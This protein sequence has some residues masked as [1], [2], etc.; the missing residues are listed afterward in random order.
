DNSAAI[1]HKW[2]VTS[3][4]GEA[5]RYVGQPADYFDFGNTDT[6]IE[7]VGGRYDTLYY[8]LHSDG[9]TLDIHSFNGM[10]AY[11]GLAV[12]TLTNTQLIITGGRLNPPINIVDSLRR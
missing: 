9:H 7:F 2:Q 5:L 8:Q 1:K 12:K 11:P 3:I 6:L 4:N 10:V